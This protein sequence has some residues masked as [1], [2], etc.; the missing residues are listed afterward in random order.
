M[1]SAIMAGVGNIQ[2]FDGSG[3]LILTSKTLTDSGISINTTGEDIRGGLSSPLIG[4]YFHDSTFDLNL[5]DALF[6]LEY[7]S[8]N[9][10]GAITIGGSAITEEQVTIV[11]ENTITVTGTP[12]EFS[13]FGTVGYYTI[14]GKDNYQKITFTGKNAT[15]S[16]LTVGT[17][18]C[19]KY[20][21]EYAN[22]RQFIV[23]STIIPAECYAILTAP[24][25]SAGGEKITASSK[26]GD[27]VVE[28]PRFQLSGAQEFSDYAV[29]I[30]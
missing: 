8:L 10:G 3:N 28:I 13:T 2:L 27:L 29:L 24:L 21:N 22:L 18:V 15:V 5:V 12:Q 6:S 19:V 26:I 14:A 1:A 23:P 30:W 17:T 20:F 11:A 25:F 4:R 16:G 9:V 7:L